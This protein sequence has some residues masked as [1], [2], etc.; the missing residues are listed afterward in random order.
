MKA[1]DL[2]AG[3]GWDIAAQNLGWDVEGWEIDPATQVTRA[4]NGL[5]T[6]GSD[7]L[8]VEALPGDSD[9][10]IA[11]PPCTTLSIAGSGTGRANMSAILRAVASYRDGHPVPYYRLA[12]ETDPRAALVLEPLRVALLSRPTYLAWEQVPPVLP[13][14]EDCADVLETRGGYSVVTGVLDA[15]D[16]G[17]PQVRRRAFLLARRDG[18]AVRFPQPTHAG[19]HVSMAQALGWGMTQRPYYTLACSRASG[20]GPDKEKVG[21]S[22]A[23]LGLYAERAAGRWVPHP[24][25]D[26]DPSIRLTLADCAALQTFPPDFV[27]HGTSTQRFTQVGNAV[28]PLLACAVLAA[29]TASPRR[30]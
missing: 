11:S 17:V 1:R 30:R 3:V 2:F 8:D 7:V 16:Y 9:I 10:D 14:W 4:A 21:G 20:G 15:A 19:R 23:R 5:K 28:P 6:A 13:I 29:V 24:T 26:H 25:L 27:F 22:K 18:R 12:A